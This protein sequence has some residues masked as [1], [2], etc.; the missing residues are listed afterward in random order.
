MNPN[1]RLLQFSPVPEFVEPVNVALIVDD[2]RTR[3]LY[4]KDFRR[5]RCVVPDF[6]TKT[7]CYMLDYL[8]SNVAT[9][10]SEFITAYIANQ[11]A[12]F[13]LSEIH[14]LETVPDKT[15]LGALTDSYLRRFRTDLEGKDKASSGYIESSLS[16]LLLE[17]VG[18]SESRLRKRAKPSTFLRT[19]RAKNVFRK[20]NISVKRVLDGDRGIVLIDGIDLAKGNAKHLGDRTSSI[21][22][23]FFMFDKHRQE[24]ERAEQ[25]HVSRAAVV[26]NIACRAD[27]S[28]YD[29]FVNQLERDS[30]ILVDPNYAE[31]VQKLKAACNKAQG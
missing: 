21:A 19:N 22:H 14:P 8:D 31:S 26:F 2:G 6:N 20:S 24:I 3:I 5:L 12:Q 29:Y 23:A 11:S 27:D 13:S 10:E 15:I 9:M 18:V 28:H 17:D 7:L 1:Y 30:D 4:D 16:R 25:R